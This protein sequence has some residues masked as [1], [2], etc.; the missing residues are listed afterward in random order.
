[1]RPLLNPGSHLLA[2][3]LVAAAASSVALELVL[4]AQAL[5]LYQGLR[6]LPTESALIAC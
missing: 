3:T 1:M 2:S 6:L 5:A 4:Q